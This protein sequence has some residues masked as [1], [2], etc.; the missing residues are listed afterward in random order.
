[1]PWV[2]A[3]GACLF[4]SEALPVI[5]SAGGGSIV[6]VASIS[7]LVGR[8]GVAGYSAAKGAIL[9]FSRQLAIEVAEDSIRV[10]VVAP[11]H[12]RTGMTEPLFLAR[13]EG[14]YAKGV[15]SAVAHTP[16]KRSAEPEEIAAPICFFLSEDGGFFTG[17]LL[18]PDGGSP[19][20]EL[21]RNRSSCR[22]TGNLPQQGEQGV[23]LP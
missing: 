22:H 9:A 12:V 18:V 17:A 3:A 23:H 4:Q 5:R 19:A 16:Q 6:N 20:L 14:D 13:G 21:P 7:A 2:R 8:D 11:G 15:A 10:N 1:M